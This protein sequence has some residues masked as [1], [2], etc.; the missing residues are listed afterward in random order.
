M[1][2]TNCLAASTLPSLTIEKLVTSPNWAG[3]VPWG[4]VMA[5]TTPLFLDR[6]SLSE[7]HSGQVGRASLRS[8]ASSSSRNDDQTIIAALPAKWAARGVAASCPLFLEP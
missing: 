2:S 7:R 6:N 4:P 3:S 1:Y 5:V 8:P